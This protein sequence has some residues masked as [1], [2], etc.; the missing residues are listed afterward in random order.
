MPGPRE[1]EAD[2]LRG[3]LRGLETRLAFQRAEP[4][5]PAT[6]ASLMQALDELALRLNRQEAAAQAR[7]ADLAAAVAALSTRLAEGQAAMVARL[8]VALEGAAQAGAAQARDPGAVRAVLLIAAALATLAVSA[9]AV[10]VA[11]RP[12]MTPPISPERFRLHLPV[13]GPPGASSEPQDAAG[14]RL[15]TAGVSPQSPSARP[16]G[17]TFADVE[18]AL[19]RGDG[20]ALARLTALAQAGD[21]DAQLHLAGLYETAGAG[22]PRDL[23]AARLWTR[24][25]AGAGSRLAMHNLGLFLSEGDGGARDM[26][27]AAAWFRRAAERGVV[28][29]QYNLGMLFEAGRGVP[30]N[31]RE[32][33]RWFSIAAN[34]G[35]VAAR[36]KQVAI[37]ARFT[38]AE[39]AA[40][41]REVADYRPG[42]SLGPADDLIVPP[43]ETLAETQALLDRQGYYV[44]PLDGLASPAFRA[45]ARAYRRDHAEARPE[46]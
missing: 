3:V 33:Y 29:S 18:A 14:S 39:R 20:S 1:S 4:L 16:S 43:A 42:P 32:A 44:G 46:P 45:A 23:A 31:L 6:A 26:V 11:T 2:D 40:L 21:P 34:A 10:L 24:R 19:R 13:A 37:E 5:E 41:D 36:E 35:D 7:D 8:D 17:E 9:A 15:P 28:D 27:E 25:A 12:D 30:R 22:L 38:P